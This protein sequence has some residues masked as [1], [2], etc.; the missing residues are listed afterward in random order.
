MQRFI[1]KPFTKVAFRS[2]RETESGLK[3]PGRRTA[4]SKRAGFTLIELLVVLAIVAIIVSLILPRLTLPY[5]LPSPAVIAFLEDARSESLRRMETVRI[6]DEMDR[7][8]AVPIDKS[9]ALGNSAARP[10]DQA[11]RRGVHPGNHLVTFFHDGTATLSS[12]EIRP[13]GNTS[14]FKVEVFVNPFNGSIDHQ[15]R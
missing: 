10:G 15:L 6:F 5:R 2:V 8:V 9:F 12:F 7:L 1:R 4:T 13:P 11:G 14:E 3:R